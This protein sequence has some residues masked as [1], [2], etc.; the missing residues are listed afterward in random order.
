[1]GNLVS[2]KFYWRKMA[3]YLGAEGPMARIMLLGL[4]GAGKTLLLYKL[5]LGESIPTTPTIG[6]NIETVKHN[7]VQLCIWDFSGNASGSCLRFTHQLA[8]SFNP[9]LFLSASSYPHLFRQLKS[10]YI[11]RRQHSSRELR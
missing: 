2:Y 11:R 5:K 8:L 3:S 6:F 7:F 4:D 9:I 10:A 1:M